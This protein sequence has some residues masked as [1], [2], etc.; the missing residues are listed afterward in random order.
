MEGFIMKLETISAGIMFAAVMAMAGCSY[1]DHGPDGAEVV[2]AG[3]SSNYAVDDP[4]YDQ[5][6]Y[7]GDYWVWHDRDG[8]MHREGRADHERR[9]NVQIQRGRSDAGQRDTGQANRSALENR[10]AQDN[11]AAQQ[12]RSAQE[13]RSAQNNRATPQQQGGRN[14]IPQGTNAHGEQGGPPHGTAQAGHSG[15][16]GP[17]HGGEAGHADG[18]NADHR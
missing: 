13:N 14:E 4:Y 2:P 8:H 18:D 5:G 15:G 6:G 9:A 11:R 16:E 3:Y 7:D 1:H 10:A 17:S 12:N